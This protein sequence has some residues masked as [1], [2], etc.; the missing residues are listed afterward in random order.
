MAKKLKEYFDLDCITFLADQIKTV[1][2]DFDKRKFVNT[3]KPKLDDFELKDRVRLIGTALHDFVP[4]DYNSKIN[5]LGQIL[6]PENNGAFGTFND[7]FWQWPLSSV[8]EQYGL[9]HRKVSFDFIYEMT[10]RSTGEFA[11]RGFL[12]QDPEFVF[13][14]L[15]KWSGDKNFHVRRLS[16]EGLRPLLPWA[17]KCTYFVDEPKRIFDHLRAL[18][19]DSERYVLNSVANHMGDMLKLNY[20]AS[21]SELESWSIK[22]GEDRKWLIRHALRNLRKKNDARAIALSEKCAISK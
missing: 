8:V 18:S 1:E 5:V 19:D 12:I 2:S 9:E 15:S 11:V 20:E 17:K 6:G 14:T 7:Y 4:G 10:K 21:I 16:S 3:L 13:K 22:A